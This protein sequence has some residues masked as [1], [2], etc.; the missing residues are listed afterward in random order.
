MR[1]PRSTNR[2]RAL[3]ENGMR[4]APS[5]L[6]LTTRSSP[7]NTKRPSGSVSSTTSTNRFCSLSSRVRP[8]TIASSCSE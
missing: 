1:G 3:A 2:G 8:A 7:S 5:R 4:A 6:A